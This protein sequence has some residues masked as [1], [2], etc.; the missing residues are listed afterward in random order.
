MTTHTEHDRQAISDAINE[1]SL[2]HRPVTEPAD[3]SVGFYGA[4]YC[5]HCERTFPCPTAVIVRG[6]IK[7]TIEVD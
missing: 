4:T 7:H 2:L 6:C 3:P 1:L 5:D